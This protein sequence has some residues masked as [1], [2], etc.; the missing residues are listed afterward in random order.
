MLSGTLKFL[1]PSEELYHEALGPWDSLITLFSAPHFHVEAL[2]AQMRK[3]FSER[4][5]LREIIQ[6][7]AQSTGV[8]E[9]TEKGHGG[10]CEKAAIHKPQKEAYRDSH[11]PDLQIWPPEL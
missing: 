11:H 5:R 8:D 3:G 6:L 1:L 2:T 7:E 10:C 9:H 4:G